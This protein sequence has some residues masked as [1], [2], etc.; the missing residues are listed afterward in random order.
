MFPASALA[1]L[2]LTARGKV[3]LGIVCTDESK[4]TGTYVDGGEG[5]AFANIYVKYDADGSPEKYLYL[6]VTA[7]TQ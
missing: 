6:Q 3:A 1:G 4:V 7:A 5:S 2:L